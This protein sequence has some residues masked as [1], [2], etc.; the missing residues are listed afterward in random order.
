M[1]EFIAMIYEW[2]GYATD[3]GEHLRG[4]D[5]TCSGFMGTDLYMQV[6]VIML[7]TNAALFVFMYFLV[8][9]ITTSYSSRKSWWITAGL[10]AVVSFGI[11]YSLPTTIQACEQL[12]FH[13]GDL[14]LYGIANA[15][16]STVVFALLTSF[17]FPRNFSTNCRL[18]TFWKP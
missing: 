18:T 10:G 1:T 11:A 14:M 5:V 15:V 3:L 13:A 17:P 8:D 4:L 2:F 9:K 7:V 16:W 12:D 6:F